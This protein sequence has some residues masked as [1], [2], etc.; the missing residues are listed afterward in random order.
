MQQIT[1][2]LI[3][4]QNKSNNT[5]FELLITHVAYKSDFFFALISTN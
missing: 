3:S 1:R 4:A 2:L 5:T